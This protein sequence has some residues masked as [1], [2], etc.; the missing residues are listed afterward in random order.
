MVSDAALQLF[1]ALLWNTVL[2]CAPVLGLTLLVGVGVS[3]FQAVTQIQ[4]MSLSFLPKLVAA[5][6]GLVAFGP[7]M[8]RRLVSYAT[9][10]ISSLPGQF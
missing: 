10:V 6:I 8:L 9:Q 2:I 7:W 4:D 3:I 5:F 1:S